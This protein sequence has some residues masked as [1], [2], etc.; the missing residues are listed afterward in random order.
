MQKEF[1]LWIQYTVQDSICF[2]H[3]NGSTVKTPIVMLDSMLFYSPTYQ[4]QGYY[5]SYEH[6]I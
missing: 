6:S 4:L 5:Y 1:F 3:N 2:S